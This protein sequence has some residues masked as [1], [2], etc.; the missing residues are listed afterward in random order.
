MKRFLLIAAFVL[1]ASP[2]WAGPEMLIGFFGK[3]DPTIATTFLDGDWQSWGHTGGSIGNGTDDRSPT[4]YIYFLNGSGGDI[5]KTVVTGAG[6]FGVWVKATMGLDS[7]CTF[8]IDAGTPVDCMPGSLSTYTH[9]EQAV[10]EGT[11]TLTIHGTA[12]ATSKLSL[13]DIHYTG[14][15]A[16][17]W[18]AVNAING[19]IQI[20]DDFDLDTG[21]GSGVTSSGNVTAAATCD[22]TG[23]V[24]LIINGVT[25][26]SLTCSGSP[27]TATLSGAVTAGTNTVR[28]VGTGTPFT[29]GPFYVPMP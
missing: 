12:G 7:T 5:S 6:T 11:H 28:I 27:L 14:T 24:S 2:A 21:T 16:A 20:A 15:A 3:P 18:P 26:D 25:A 22:G 19:R 8:D 9:F 23:S 13:D 10:T 29:A 17:R 1:I 4:G